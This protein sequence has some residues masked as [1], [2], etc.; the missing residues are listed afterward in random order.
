MCSLGSATLPVLRARL[1]EQRELNPE[2]GLFL[3]ELSELQ[4]KNTSAE[5]GFYP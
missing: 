4:S 2:D 3:Y 5:F 1:E